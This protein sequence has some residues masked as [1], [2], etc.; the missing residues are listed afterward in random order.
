MSPAPGKPGF[1]NPPS[2]NA[3]AMRSAAASLHR[4]ADRDAIDPEAERALI[5]AQARV[6]D[7]GV[8]VLCQLGVDL[9]H[10]NSHGRV[11]PPLDLFFGIADVRQSKSLVNF[12]GRKHA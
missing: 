5:E 6:N 7:V 11:A 3:A 1:A 4:P 12:L 8:I 9:L 10:W 2:R